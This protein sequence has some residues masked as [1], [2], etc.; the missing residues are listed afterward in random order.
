V[1]KKYSNTDIKRVIFLCVFGVMCGATSLLVSEY[2]FFK[3]QSDR[4]LVLQDDYRTYI[5]AV[6]KILQD[7]NKTKERLDILK[8]DS[9]S[10]QSRKKKKR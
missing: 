3:R 7:Y 6:N 10:A 9:F 2:L 8:A 4:L 1:I 5:A